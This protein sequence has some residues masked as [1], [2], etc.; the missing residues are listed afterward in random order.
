[1]KVRKRGLQIRHRR[2]A[3]HSGEQLRLFWHKFELP[4]SDGLSMPV[5]TVFTKRYNEED[6]GRPYQPLYQ[7]TAASTLA[8]LHHLSTL[9]V[10]RPTLSQQRS[11]MLR[12]SHTATATSSSPQTLPRLSPAGLRY[13]IRLGPQYVMMISGRVQPWS[14]SP[15]LSFTYSRFDISRPNMPNQCHLAVDQKSSCILRYSIQAL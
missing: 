9:C 1:M 13:L 12:T 7:H 8:G 10:F 15:F 2:D 3:Q 4:G 11:A 5:N 14:S 6:E